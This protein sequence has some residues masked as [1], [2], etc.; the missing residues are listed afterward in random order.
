MSYTFS[1]SRRSLPV[2]CLCLLLIVLVLWCF[3]MVPRAGAVAVEAATVAYAGALIGTILVGAGVLFSSGGDMAAVGNA[4]YKSL[5]NSSAAIAS[6]IA[7]VSSWAVS[8]GKKLASSA[9]HVGKDVFAEIVNAFKVTYSDG[10]VLPVVAAHDT[11]IERYY[12]TAQEAAVVAF[13][14]AHPS[15]MYFTDSNTISYS[16]HWRLDISADR[17]YIYWRSCSPTGSITD[18]FKTFSVSKAKTEWKSAYFSLNTLSSIV[19][20]DIYGVWVD[21]S[22]TEHTKCLA[23]NYGCALPGYYSTSTFYLPVSCTAPSSDLK[24]P[25]DDFLVKM[26][27]LPQVDSATG[28]VTYPSDMPYILLIR[29]LLHI[30]LILTALRCRM[31]LMMF[32]LTRRRAKI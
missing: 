12:T 3:F 10:K 29:L 20:A 28:S 18:I 26:P 16:R 25:S 4:M 7:A 27:D 15:E 22:G 2:R 5:S 24:Y 17:H 8:H 31:C 32:Q 11:Y 13:F 6:K 19:S 14:D 30:R 23:D 1:L 9:Y 21:E